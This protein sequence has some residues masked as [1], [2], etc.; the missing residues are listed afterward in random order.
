MEIAP[1]KEDFDVAVI[2]EIQM[3][4][5]ESRGYAVS[6]DIM[7]FL[8]LSCMQTFY[9][10]R[11]LFSFSGHVL[12]WACVRKRY[13][14]VEEWRLYHLLKNSFKLVGIVLN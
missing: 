7:F 14:F 12:S 4:G 6:D 13:M 8:S 3:I 2:D 10:T 5:D 9:N 11:T 1:I